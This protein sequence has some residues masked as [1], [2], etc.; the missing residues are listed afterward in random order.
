M[1]ALT[2]APFLVNTIWYGPGMKDRLGRQS[3]LDAG[4]ARLGSHGH[5]GL[6]VMAIAETLGVTKG[7]FYWHFRDHPEYLA[8]L[9][10]EWERSHTQQVIDQVES[11]GG[12]PA[13]KLRQLLAVTLAAD[14]SST[15]AIRAWGR[16][17]ATVASAVWRVDEKRLAYTAGLLEALGW[18]PDQAATL[19]SWS[20]AALI[21]HFALRGPALN[22]AQIDLVLST[23]TGAPRAG[24]PQ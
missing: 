21:G 22:D 9:L 15:Q 4:L 6:R 7:S 14:P 8:A 18:A 2:P 11:A 23:I 10:D 20:Y 5:E 19:A 1:E 16:V 24:R 17:D 13:A 12:A 3:W